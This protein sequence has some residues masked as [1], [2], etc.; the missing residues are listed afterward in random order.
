MTIKPTVTRTIL[1]VV[2]LSLIVSLSSVNL[3]KAQEKPILD[4]VRDIVSAGNGKIRKW[5]TPPRI[6]VIYDDDPYR[7]KALSMVEELN[8][9]V[10]GFPGISV[11]F[12]NLNLIE[13]SI[14][15]RTSFSY[16]REL[17]N[18]IVYTESHLLIHGDNDTEAD[19][20][21]DIYLFLTDLKTGLFFGEIFAI[22]DEEHAHTRR[23]YAE[24]TAESTCYMNV[25]SR[26]DQLQTAWI[27]I[28]STKEPSHIRH[29]IHHE[30]THTLGAVHHTDWSSYF[31]HN[32]QSGPIASTD[33]DFD[34]MR[35]L[36]SENISPGDSPD[37]VAE[38]FARITGEGR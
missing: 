26:L 21:A 33:S 30:V 19:L 27:F 25:Q 9:T 23:R 16:E 20:E 31:T 34:L 13:G 5:V 4:Q 2:I 38:E 32:K 37:Q 10:E 24:D 6:L 35:A 11:K 17:D 1:S 29:C 36:Y 7:A 22:E 3:A 8:T 12:F 14:F 18:G 28:N 15:G